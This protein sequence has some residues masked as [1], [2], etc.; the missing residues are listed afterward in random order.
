MFP[1]INP[2]PTSLK[3][4][5]FEILGNKFEQHDIVIDKLCDNVSSPK[6]FE[7][8]SKFIVAIYESGY[9]KSVEQHREIL[10]KAGIETHVVAEKKQVEP[11]IFKSNSIIK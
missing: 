9:L 11:T 6:E 4:F 3:K 5:L 1:G 7:R 10:S 8:I 2:F